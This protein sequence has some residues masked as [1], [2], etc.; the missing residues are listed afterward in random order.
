MNTN[1]LE[2]EQSKQLRAI[3]AHL[4]SLEDAYSYLYDEDEKDSVFSAVDTDTPMPVQAAVSILG[5]S[6]ERPWIY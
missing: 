3:R 1:V 2:A 6:P 5:D 4:N